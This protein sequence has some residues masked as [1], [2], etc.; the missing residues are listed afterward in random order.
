MA[1]QDCQPKAAQKKTPPTMK[2]SGARLPA[3]AVGFSN[4][5]AF[6]VTPIVPRQSSRS[7]N[8]SG[9][10]RQESSCDFK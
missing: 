5:P 2:A 9:S 4:R 10:E 7:D 8:V 1:P 6:G 3:V